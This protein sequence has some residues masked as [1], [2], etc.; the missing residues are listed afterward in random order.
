MSRLCTVRQELCGEVPTRGSREK[1]NQE[2][3]VKSY[4]CGSAVRSEND[5]KEHV[6]THLPDK[7]YR[8]EECFKTYQRKIN[9]SQDVRT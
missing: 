5:L 6:K 3:L 4:P 9:L 8:R 2:E 1:C 7:C